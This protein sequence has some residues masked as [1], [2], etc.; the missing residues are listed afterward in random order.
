[1]IIKFQKIKNVGSFQLFEWDKVNPAQIPDGRGG[2]ESYDTQFKK[3]NLL[4]GENGTGK[5]TVVKIFKSINRDTNDLAKNWD[6][7]N[8]SREIQIALNGTN[9][10]D[11][12]ESS[13]WRNNILR[14]KFIFFDR[15]FI[16][17]HVHS[18]PIARET[19]HDKNTGKLIL[20]LG[21]FGYYKEQLDKLVRLQDELVS[22]NRTLETDVNQT[23]TKVISGQSENDVKQVFDNIKNQSEEE[24]Q[25]ANEVESEIKTLEESLSKA[26]KIL[27]ESAE[28]KRLEELSLATK[29]DE[30]DHQKIKD[31][32]DFSVSIGTATVIEKIRGR[33]DFIQ[34]GLKEL[35]KEKLDKCPFC[36]Q[37]I[38]TGNEYLHIVKE[39]DQIFDNEFT[40]TQDEVE[41]TLIGYKNALLSVLRSS[42]P[43]ENRERI[44]KSNK[45]LGKEDSLP[46]LNLLQAD[47]EVIQHEIGLVDKKLNNIL[48]KNQDSKITDISKMIKELN[49]KI[50]KYNEKAISIN[51]YVEKTKKEVE[52]GDIQKNRDQLVER[53]KQ[54]KLGLFALR[55]FK[56]LDSIYG[57][58]NKY[59]TNKTKIDLI[60]TVL[61]AFIE[62][63]KKKFKE[64]VDT[65][66]TEIEK[67]VHIFCPS[68]DIQIVSPRVTYD[69]RSDDVVCGFEVRYKDKD[70]FLTLSDGERQSIALAYFLALLNQTKNKGGKIVVF[71]DPINSFDAGRRKMCAEYI[72]KEVTPFEQSFVLTCDPLFRTYVYKT[73]GRRF[74]NEQSY[75]YILK[76]ASSSIHYRN[77]KQATIYSVFKSEFQNIGMVNGTDENII[78]YGQRL[79]YCIEEVK[80]KYLGYGHDSLDNILNQV[81]NSNFDKFKNSIDNLMEIYTYCNSGGLAHYPRDGQTSWDELK[82][83][84]NR[85]LR[86]GI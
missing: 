1:M 35:R 31:A 85:Y 4:Y 47:S 68:I 57:A 81:K 45:L 70:R 16:N 25:E 40:R 5:S 53:L 63:V 11:F 48:T 22:R 55:N 13:L 30:V 65:Y 33:E 42:E 21:N 66:F 43:G 76:S 82:V 18:F 71:D 37:S 23:K 41:K 60:K 2:I 77:K 10:I 83:Y 24:R 54:N 26:N 15:G 7:E 50:G 59:Q 75:Y 64:F 79:R 27:D 36:E 73:I 8:E 17:S 29:K 69:L 28:V 58:E 46:T 38:K 52:T 51:D 12:S 56:E 49:E 84:T 3:Y 14:E 67:Y 86:M 72:L 34:S 74:G 19:G 39:Y 44:E 9:T 78:L 20:L 61:D 80:D 6:R 32:F 62:K